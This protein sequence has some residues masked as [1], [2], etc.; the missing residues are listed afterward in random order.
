MRTKDQRQKASF[1]KL[2]EKV[3]LIENIIANLKRG[4]K[5]KQLFFYYCNHVPLKLVDLATEHT[6]GQ[7]QQFISPTR[8]KLKGLLLVSLNSLTKLNFVLF[9]AKLHLFSETLKNVNKAI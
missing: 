8:K 1:T 4:K 7:R 3:V 6:Q 5:Y 2:S 9:W